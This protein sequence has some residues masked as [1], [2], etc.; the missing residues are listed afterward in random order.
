MMDCVDKLFDERL[1]S[2][3]PLDRDKLREAAIQAVFDYVVAVPT[4][5]MKEH[6]IEIYDVA[7]RVIPR[8]TDMIERRRRIWREFC[9]LSRVCLL[10][11]VVI[12]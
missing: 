4:D 11:E 7:C 5:E 6:L 8:H 1:A 10:S 2:F 12:V 9:R 3:G